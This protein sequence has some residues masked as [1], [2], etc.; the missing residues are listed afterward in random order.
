MTRARLSL[1]IAGALAP[2]ACSTSAVNAQ[3]VD[4]YALGARAAYADVRLVSAD[5][6]DRTLDG[7]LLGA[8]GRASW[9][10]LQMDVQYM[11]GRVRGSEPVSEGADIR[12][13]QGL[14]GIRVLPW[15]VL[16]AGPRFLETETS[17]GERHTLRW[18]AGA[19]V[20]VPLVRDWV[21][22]FGSAVGSV[23]GSELD[24]SPYTGRGGVT[25]GFT[26]TPAGLPT[27]ASVGYR[28]DKEGNES[29]VRTIETIQ[30]GIG[31]R[32]G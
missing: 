17:G 20:S 29:G 15:V 13:A 31:W 6:G 22:G 16:H 19:S 2:I 8:E 10:T 9:R 27:W 1:C 5:E 18:Q 25:V 12:V 26:L 14:V 30:I 32:G 21:H 7:I 3:A 4:G 28:M 24:P 11:Q 23:A